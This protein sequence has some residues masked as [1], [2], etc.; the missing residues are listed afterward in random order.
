[1]KE[2]RHFTDLFN[3]DSKLFL[4]DTLQY[5]TEKFEMKDKVNSTDE[6]A[7]NKVVKSVF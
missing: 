5:K 7:S 6:R 4:S 3:S 2:K 1:M